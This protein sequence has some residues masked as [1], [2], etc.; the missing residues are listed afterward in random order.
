MPRLTPTTAARR[1]ANKARGLRAKSRREADRDLVELYAEDAA[2][3]ETVADL[4][5]QGDRQSAMRVA[6]L[7]DTAAREE[8]PPAV[9]TYMGGELTPRGRELLRREE[10][11]YR[12]K[13]ARVA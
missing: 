1:L 10:A 12:A 2:A 9:W 4:L 7:L 3:L 6:E 5:K 8:I 13:L 11:R